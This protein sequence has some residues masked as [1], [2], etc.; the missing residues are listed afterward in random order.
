MVFGFSSFGGQDNRTSG[1][2]KQKLKARKTQAEKSRNRKLLFEGLEERRV[3][4]GFVAG[5]IQGQD[6]WSGGNI[7][8]SPNVYQAIDQTGLNAH[9]GIGSWQVSNNTTN[10]NYNGNFNGWPF[11][12]GL[13]AAAG[14]PSS[15]APAD[16]FSATYY[17]KSGSAI[18]DGSNIEIDLGTVAGDDR[19]TFMSIR[20]LADANGGL[21]IRM[22]EP[23][24][25][26]GGFLNTQTVSTGLSR[27]A[28]HRIDITAVFVNGAGNDTFQVSL[29]GNLL[30]NPNALSPNF[31][32]PNFGTFEGFRDGNGFS[33][34]QS[35]RL[36]FRSGA[37]P[38]SIGAFADNASQGIFVDDLSYRVY[39]SSNPSVILGSYAA[40]FETQPTN[41]Y[42]DQAGDFTI[43]VNVGG[44]GLDAGDIV[45]W[46]G[47]SPVSGLV[48]GTDAFTT[49]QGGVNGVAAGG[50]VYVA[51]GSYVGGV[52]IDR[53]MTVNGIG[54]PQVSSVDLNGQTVGFQVGADNVMLQGFNI[55]GTATG[56]E[57]GVLLSDKPAGAPFTNGTIQNN[58]LSNLDYAIATADGTVDFTNSIIQ[59]N[60]ISI[61][62]VTGGWGVYLQSGSGHVVY[63]N[64]ITGN[65]NGGAILVQ[66]TNNVTVGGTG[67]GQG[68][69]I[70][71]TALAAYIT[72]A[73]N[74]S[75][76]GNTI[77]GMSG[78]SGSVRAEGGVSGLS[79]TQ[80]SITGGSVPA[81]LLRDSSGTPNSGVVVN[82]NFLTGN[83]YGIRVTSNGLT[84]T[85]DARSNNIS[86]NSLG[87]VLNDSPNLVD[88]SG[89]Y[90]GAPVQATIVA[91][92]SGTGPIDY[93]PYLNLATDT[94]AAPGFQGD[95]SV[96]T[97]HPSGAQ[98]GATGRIQEGVNLLADGSLTGSARTVNV[99]AGTYAENVDI[100]KSLTLRGANYAIDAVTGVRTA[101]S[102]ID[103]ASGSAITLN[104]NAVYDATIQ[105]FE[106]R[107]ATAGNFNTNVGT[108]NIQF[109]NNRA[110]GVTGSGLA[111]DLGLLG[112]TTNVTAFG[113]LFSGISANAMQ[114]NNS[115]GGLLNVD[116][117]NN[118]VDTTGNAGINT[119]S[120]TSAILSNNV[121]QNTT[122]QAIQVAGTANGTLTISNNTI[123][124]AN[125]SN[126]AT[127]GAI[128]IGSGSFNA[129]SLAITNNAITGG[130]NGLFINSSANP[131]P[132]TLTGNTFAS[133]SNAAIAFGTGAA[134]FVDA[135]GGNTFN[136]VASNVATLS[137]LFAIEDQIYHRVDTASLTG[138]VRVKAGN[139]YV[140]TSSGSVQRGV[141]AA[142]SGDTVHVTSGTFI[143][144]V[145]VNKNLTIDGDDLSPT[146]INGG[147]SPVISLSGASTIILEDLVL[148]GSA[149]ALGNS[150]I[151][152]LTLDNVSSSL[153]SSWTGTTGT[154]NLK[155]KTG[156]NDSISATGTSFG[157]S[158]GNILG[159]VS[160]AANGVTNLN[161]DSRDGDDTISVTA[162]A[163]G[164]TL[165][166]VDGNS[167]GASGDTLI[168]DATGAS[169]TINPASITS[170]ARQTV[171][172][173]N[174]EN[175]Q[176][177]NAIIQGTAGADTFVV[178]FVSAS[179][180]RIQYVLNG[181][182][183]VVI[184]NPVSLTFNGSTGDDVMTVDLA[185]GD[186]VPSGGLFFNGEGHDFT[187]GAPTP[188]HG[189]VLKVIGNGAN[190]EYRAFGTPGAVDKNLNVNTTYG[191][192]TATGVEPGDLSGFA[193][194]DV[195]FSGANEVL[196]IVNGVDAT[197]G[198]IPALVV[199]GTTGGNPFEGAHLWNNSQVRVLTANTSIGGTDGNDSVVINSA[200][201]AHNNANLWIDTGSGTDSVT[202]AGNATVSGSI[203]ILSQNI[204]FTGGSASASAVVLNAGTG[205]IT[206]TT[207]AVDVSAAQLTAQATTG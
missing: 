4:A 81:V 61:P 20:N 77:S 13:V 136:G 138:F 49:I 6:G 87:N 5:S 192:I 27:T 50:N 109:A 78:I 148:T 10:G 187:V 173:T 17:F 117:Q 47:P 159:T 190:A 33:Y 94:S 79:I 103:P 58:Q 70:T 26:T 59:N 131:A 163:V 116:I 16:R 83:T 111:I 195:V 126:D 39:N 2:T 99:L 188:N 82:N 185:S 181:G 104:T 194:V 9:T 124:N 55:V 72:D 107:D 198:L 40:A 76:V 130:N 105:G 31:N 132:I 179:P 88:V 42:V 120:L 113:N 80:N 171:N 84:G 165:I 147:A 60:T 110:I 67:A 121:I 145:I 108:R 28:W 203:T 12:P 122:Q 183:P 74:T 158:S 7:P 64:T 160:Y 134:G 25:V 56:N 22:A 128:R 62:T 24:G 46:N 65:V 176:I 174:I 152:S 18:A 156:A 89:S 180:Y 141:A 86:G 118:K 14:Q 112:I 36:F 100:S 30:I 106:L 135:T 29:D 101:E 15:G 166:S 98:N 199:S 97:A 202:V 37:T 66:N 43:N 35:N 142:S 51:A 167:N 53:T 189:D 200:S 85:L 191:L 41:T 155:T 119:N 95:Y 34:A 140:T 205:A 48:F 154:V 71:G 23:D 69:T 177:A 127:R 139:V 204:S 162:P 38:S 92:M 151:T 93:T 11:T 21:Q 8:I 1:R 146:I 169:I 149:S 63:G 125:T 96:L 182:T 172:Y 153:T 32:T 137:Q 168:Y 129:T 161:I 19:N 114:F 207:N 115:A 193:T 197:T 73:T 90:L 52:L 57:Y 175:L 54:L 91:S 133:Q 170:G 45:T 164:G 123:S 102:I 75:V 178:S 186:A 68:N 196:S 44:P 144:N 150:G 143:D 201:N 206:T 157:V 184:T 3:L